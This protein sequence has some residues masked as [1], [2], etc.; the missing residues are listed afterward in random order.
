MTMKKTLLMIVGGLVFTTLSLF[1]LHSVYAA[2]QTNT[3]LDAA[4]FIVENGDLLP[5]ANTPEPT[6][7]NTPQPTNTPAPTNTPTVTAT[8]DPS[9]TELLR[10][11]SFE[12]D[13]DPVDGLA[14]F[15]GLRNPTGERRLCDA[16]LARTGLCAFEFRGAGAT[17]DSILQQRA[18][19]T[20]VTFVAGSRVI[21]QGHARA[22]GAPNFRVR[23]VVTYDDG[24]VERAQTRFN[25]PSTNYLD[26]LDST[27]S[28]PLSLGI[29][30]ENVAQIRVVVWSRNSTG[31]AYFDDF[32]LQYFVSD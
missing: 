27:T 13:L 24:T 8:V 23:I 14:D 12:D 10:N 22:N 32:S 30:G 25:T 16:L 9:G 31:R 20:G 11:R 17:E 28:Q 15:W 5:P 29:A 21:L 1:T 3:P 18:D 2:M 4:A 26:I 7:T 19:L 6:N